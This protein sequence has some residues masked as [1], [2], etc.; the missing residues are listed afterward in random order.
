MYLFIFTPYKWTSCCGTIIVIATSYKS[1]VNIII[2]ED[3]DRATEI[4]KSEKWQQNDISDEDFLNI[5]RRYRRNY[6]SDIADTFKEEHKDQ[7]LL[8]SKIKVSDIE[9]PRIVEEN[10]CCI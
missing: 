8:T 3:N 7:W 10:W 4:A 5:Y 9:Y 6:F 1:A 2:E